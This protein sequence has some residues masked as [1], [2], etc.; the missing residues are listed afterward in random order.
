MSMPSRDLIRGVPLFADTDER[1]IDRLAEE[2]NDRTY[3]PGELLAEEGER[4]RTF[5][6]IESG[7]AAVLVHGNEVRRLGPGDALGEMALIDKS[8]R[9]ATVRA[10]TVVRGYQLPVWSFRPIVES[11]PEII[12][13]LF[14]A[15]AQRAREVESRT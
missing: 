4:G 9:S 12:W 14:E 13:A 2:F 8:A 6:V 11:H 3:A 1:F 10:E 15:L 5:F 7:E